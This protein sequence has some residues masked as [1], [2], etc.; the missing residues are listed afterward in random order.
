MIKEERKF[1]WIMERCIRKLYFRQNVKEIFACDWIIKSVT[2]EVWGNKTSA[3]C[4]VFD[5]INLT[6]NT[7]S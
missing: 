4:T 2:E 3:N 6:W 5:L 7:S 1:I